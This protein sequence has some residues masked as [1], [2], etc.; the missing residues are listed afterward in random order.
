MC[1]L[2]FNPTTQSANI[3]TVDI[4]FLVKKKFNFYSF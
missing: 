1:V 2:F 4:D 3:Q